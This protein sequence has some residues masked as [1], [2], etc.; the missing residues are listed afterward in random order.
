MRPGFR[1]ERDGA[2]D[3]AHVG[4]EWVAQELADIVENAAV[5]PHSLDNV[6]VLAMPLSRSCPLTSSPLEGV[7]IKRQ[8]TTDNSPRENG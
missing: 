4:A 3:L 2:K 7:Q 6:L 5:L 1:L 8:L